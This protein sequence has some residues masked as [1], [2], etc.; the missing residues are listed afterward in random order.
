MVR[1][2]PDL[3]PRTISGSMIM[4]H[5]GSGLMPMAQVTTKG[6]VNHHALGCPWR[7]CGYLRAMLPFV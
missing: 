1:S 7:P 6:Q 4:M 2:V 5:W 3:S